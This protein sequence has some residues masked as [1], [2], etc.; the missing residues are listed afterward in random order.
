MFW[1]KVA[2]LTLVYSLEDGIPVVEAWETQI[3]C[4]MGTHNQRN[5][6]ARALVDLCFIRETNFI[7]CRKTRFRTGQKFGRKPWVSFKIS[8]N[9]SLHSLHLMMYKGI[10][11]IAS[12]RVWI[13]RPC[14]KSSAQFCKFLI[15]T[16][17]CRKNVTS[18]GW[19]KGL[20]WGGIIPTLTERFPS[21]SV[22]TFMKGQICLPSP[23]I[24]EEKKMIFSPVRL[25]DCFEKILKYNSGRFSR[26]WSGNKHITVLFN[27]FLGGFLHCGSEFPS[28]TIRLLHW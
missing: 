18:H 14:F 10:F 21:S 4:A 12:S 13:F 9:R 20:Q 3:D 23:L 16:I 1:N 24:N 5:I 15:K 25:N 19:Q 8:E 27:K 26:R 6:T 22:N 11:L 7:D 28:F 17:T 2:S